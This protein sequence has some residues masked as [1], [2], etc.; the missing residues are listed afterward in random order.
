[1]TI[2][3][4]ARNEAVALVIAGESTRH[5]CK[6]LEEARKKGKHEWHEWREK[7]FKIEV[8]EAE[9]WEG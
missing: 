5:D 7:I 9:R 8:T 4:W 2:Y 6:T 1:M 3:I